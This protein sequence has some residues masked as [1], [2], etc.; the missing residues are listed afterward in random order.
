MAWFAYS[1]LSTV[2]TQVDVKAWNIEFMQNSQVVT[3]EIVID[4][5]EIY[6]GMDPIVENVS[7]HNLG[8]SNA[9]L[10]YQVVSARVLNEDLAEQEK[11]YLVD[12]LSHDLPF[13]INISL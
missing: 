1:G 13:H 8:D 12:L 6:P 11:G 9:M 7:I 10:S 2:S 3:N 4:V 5:N